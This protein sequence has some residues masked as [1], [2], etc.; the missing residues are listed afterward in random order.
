MMKF[1]AKI[2]AIRGDGYFPATVQL[3]PSQYARTG[4]V[5]EPV[6]GTS[7]RPHSPNAAT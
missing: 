3:V 2:V 7:W 6:I 5:L 4:F 1:S